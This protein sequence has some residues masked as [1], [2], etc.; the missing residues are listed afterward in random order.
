MA[1]PY[2]PKYRNDVV[3]TTYVGIPINVGPNKNKLVKGY[4]TTFKDGTSKFIYEGDT[5]LSSNFD[6]S[7]FTGKKDSKG[8]WVWSPTTSNSVQNLATREGISAENIN[9]ALYTKKQGDS[10][11]QI[12]TVLNGNRVTQLGG[13]KEAQKVDPKIPGA[14]GTST[15][16]PDYTGIGNSSTAGPSEDAEKIKK[17]SGTVRSGTRTEYGDIRYPLTLKLEKQDVIKFSIMEYKPPGLKST[18]QGGASEANRI[19]SFTASKDKTGDV[20]TLSDRK[21]L[22]TITLPIPGG[23]SDSNVANWQ[24]DSLDVLTKAGADIVGSFIGGGPSAAG[25]AATDQVEGALPGGDTSAAEATITSKMTEAATNSTN[26]QQ[27]MFGTLLNPNTELLFT[28][29]GLRQFGFTFRLTP[30]SQEEARAVRKIIRWFKQSMSVKRSESSL[31]LKS[32]NTFAIAYLH[33]GKL[34]PY[35]NRFKECALTTFNV[36]YTPDQTYM[37]YEDGSMTCYQ[38]TM[39]FQE[40]E[41]LFDDEY[42]GNDDKNIGF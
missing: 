9:K 27:R 8:N 28:G 38:L 41:P 6:Y 34:H 37:T 24:E 25:E 40:L 23:I 33:E 14:T 22:G 1:E 35:L 10:A 5:N 3:K 30:R 18:Q 2:T 29:P 15:Q 19:V 32:P 26:L 42:G 31:L 11:S 4:Q 39:S 17:E 12:A 21:I 20:P 13:T 36:D 7:T 16:A